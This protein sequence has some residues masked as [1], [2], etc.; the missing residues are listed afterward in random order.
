MKYLRR[1]GTDDIEDD[2]LTARVIG[3]AIEIHK[4][5]GPGFAESMYHRA[6]EIDLGTAGIHFLSEAP[7]SLKY[8]NRI[9]GNFELDL[10]VEGCL[11]LE[12]KAL[13]NLPQIAE[14]QVVQYL[15][16]SGLDTGLILNFG[17]STLQIK[18]K[19]RRRAPSTEDLRL[20][21]V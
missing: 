16:A 14:I 21:E 11:L 1:N 9:L 13:E 5:I 17:T 6:M 19:Y 2:P 4:E 10:V 12:L 15:K 7:Y 20:H 18:R 3:I 8:K